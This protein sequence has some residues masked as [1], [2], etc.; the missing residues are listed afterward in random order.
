MF[1]T[2]RLMK[3]TVWFVVVISHRK[4][5]GWHWSKSRHV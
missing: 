3:T 4:I 2:D 5:R 1:T